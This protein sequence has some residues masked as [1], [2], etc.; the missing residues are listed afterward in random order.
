MGSLLEGADLFQYRLDVL[1]LPL[2]GG[3]LAR[4]DGKEL[5]QLGPLVPAN[6]IHINQFADFGEGQAEPAPAQGKLQAGA[7]AL[8]IDAALAGTLRTNQALVFVIADGARVMSNSRASS[9]I[10]KV[11]SR[12][13]FRYKMFVLCA[14][15]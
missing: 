1:P 13:M 10:V 7:V 3:A 9:V 8:G 2:Q 12:G 15:A 6:V 14:A 11:C 5:R 4:Q